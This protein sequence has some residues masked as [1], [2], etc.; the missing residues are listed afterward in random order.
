MVAYTI[1][2]SQ[3][4]IILGFAYAIF[5]AIVVVWMRK[6][7]TRIIRRAARIRYA[8]EQF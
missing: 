5:D 6:P 3:S 4:S 7:L 1:G 2:I 8:P